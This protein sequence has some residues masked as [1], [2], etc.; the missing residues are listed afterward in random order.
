MR[1]C[2]SWAGRGEFDRQQGW[3]I[4]AEWGGMSLTTRGRGVEDDCWL[5]RGDFDR[6]Q[7]GWKMTTGWGGVSWAVSR[8]GGSPLD[9]GEFDC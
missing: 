2:D 4:T 8:D 9:R 1:S 6:Q 7:E 5:G 3:K